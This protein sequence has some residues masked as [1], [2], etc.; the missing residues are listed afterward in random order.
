MH[1]IDS[2][3]NLR[4]LYF[5]YLTTY[6]TYLVAVIIV[7]I[8]GLIFGG[9]LKTVTNNQTQFH[10]KVQRVI[11]RGP[12]HRKLIFLSQTFTQFVECEMP[13]YIIYSK[14]YGITFRC[15]TMIIHLQII[16]QYALNRGKHTV[17]LLISLH[18]PSA[19]LDKNLE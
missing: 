3:G 8:A 13:S 11:E 18:K 5:G 6:R 2:L 1:L 17:F 16:I 12:R 7:G 19:N 14:Q 15:F 9:S 10:E 4:S